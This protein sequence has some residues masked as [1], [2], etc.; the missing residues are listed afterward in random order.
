MLN[1]YIM[2]KGVFWII[3][4]SSF[5]LIL[6]IVIT[7]MAFDSRFAEMTVDYFAF[8]A[9]IFLVVEG[10]YKILSSRSSSLSNQVLRA[11]R[12]TIGGCIFTIHL[13]QLMRY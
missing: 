12:V 2:R 9:G 7:C 1:S 13:L 10:V 8:L 6:A 5:L 3:L 11:I 4:L